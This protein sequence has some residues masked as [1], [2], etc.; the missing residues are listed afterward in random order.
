MGF[1]DNM[2]QAKST[3][4]VSSSGS[5][6]SRGCVGGRG[7]G[8][9]AKFKAPRVWCVRRY[10][11]NC[12]PRSLPRPGGLAGV[13]N[14]GNGDN[15]PGGL[16]ANKIESPDLGPDDN[17]GLSSSG[18]INPLLL[19]RCSNDVRDDFAGHPAAKIESRD[20][21]MSENL[22]GTD[23]TG[24]MHDVKSKLESPTVSPDHMNGRLADMPESVGT[25]LS[26][27]RNVAAMSGPVEALKD[28]VIG[29]PQDSSNEDVSGSFKAS[30]THKYPPRRKFSAVRRFPP[31]CGRNVK[32][33]TK[34][35]LEKVVAPEE[36]KDV[37]MDGGAHKGRS[38]SNVL[39]QKPV[40]IRLKVKYSTEKATK[41]GDDVGQECGLDRGIRSP[42]QI[43]ERSKV[44]HMSDNKGELKGHLQKVASE[45]HSTKLTV[46][47]EFDDLK[48]AP[49]R[50]AVFGHMASTGH[51]STKGNNLLSD[52]SQRSSSNKKQVTAQEQ[53][54]PITSSKVKPSCKPIRHEFS[55][56]DDKLDDT[57]DNEKCVGS[58][59]VR[60]RT[61]LSVNLT[62]FGTTTAKGTNS[63]RKKVREVL[64]LFHIICRKL[65]HE[66]ETNPNKRKILKRVDCLAAKEL[67]SR[68]M[69]LNEG[70]RIIGA[71]PGVEVGDEFLYRF[72][73]NII[74]FHRHTQA[75][76]DCMQQGQDL[77]AVSIVASGG[78]EDNLDSSD[79]LDYTGQ[80]G[81]SRDKEA[82]D[83]KLEK[84]NLALKNSIKAKN[85]V[86]VIRAEM[87]LS[88]VYVYDGLYTVEKY[89]QE[90]GPHGKLVFKFRMV[91]VPGQ[92]ELAWK[93]VKKSK[94]SKV[95]E[96]LCVGDISQ[97]KELIPICAVNTIDN[98]KPPT[99][100]YITQMIYP[101]SLTRPGGC[102]CRN[103]CTESGS[104]ACV[105]KNDEHIPYNHNGA[106][107]EAKDLVYECGPSCK[108]PPSCYNRVS[109]HGIK[110]QLEIFKTHSRGWGVRSL[111]SISSGSFI[112]EYVGEL[113]EDNEAEQRTNDEYLFDIGGHGDEEDV[114][115]SNFTIDAA[116]FGNVGRFINHSCSPNLYAQNV[117]YDHG[118][119]KF[120]HIMLFAAENIP[121]LRELTYHYNYQIDQV[122]DSY[123]NI[124]RKN[125]YCGSAECTGRMY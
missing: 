110:F 2:M 96:G 123:G 60:R 9:G 83:Q 85:P 61:N 124:K 73:L 46:P 89:W 38:E 82:E 35:E 125:C 67:K 86:R 113:L 40:K 8:G 26:E 109:Q 45:R 81:N 48:V 66:A 117:L 91:R 121:P 87:K 104:C 114:Q 23:I 16:S 115:D 52:G 14:V 47:K 15:D 28:D 41:S 98:E 79:V 88:K 31:N 77:L 122:Y 3:N 100:K 56:A 50:A 42:Y 10:P 105:A 5:S 19:E 106:I 57:E 94:K 24:K 72:E 37:S 51:S 53:R 65:V 120:P 64:R 44:V 107:V 11:P 101:K 71:F 25:S 69:C 93:Q 76:I 59:L 39:E 119:R 118:N 12:G 108:C 116:E 32:P 102:N 6:A 29:S 17:L 18:V 21:R 95:R 78:Y 54:K 75:G 103:G 1:V 20:L 84:G 13:S 80:G 99:F 43:G 7:D 58:Q 112:C 33:P 90:P 36:V 34:Q 22:G 4:V 30:T 92:P 111:N 62:P 55:R 68:G 27:S 49:K 63:A 74:G 97:G 70:R